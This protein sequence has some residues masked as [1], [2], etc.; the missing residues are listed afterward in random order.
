M[1][2]S[3]LV[4]VWPLSPL[5]EG[6]L[7]HALYDEQGTDVYVSQ[8]IIGLDGPLDAVA[9]RAS[10]QALLD[11]H[12]SLRAGFQRRSSGAP[13][14]LIMRR[15]VLPWREEDLSGLAED[16]AWAESERIGLEERA[17]RFDLSVPPL[18]KVLLVKVGPDRYRMMV[19]LH[20][21]LVDG[22]SLPLL[23]RE[24]WTAYEAGGSTRDLPPVTPYRE[25]LAW[26]ARQDKDAALEV[27]RKAL[28][29]TRE[30]TLVVPVVPTE[31]NAAAAPSDTVSGHASAELDA[32]LR[33]L[34]RVHGLTLNTVVQAAWA[35]M[36]GKLTGRRDVVFGA[37][38]AG[39]PA[40]LPG[41][42][43][44]LGL[45][46]N[47][48][49][50][51]VRFDPAQTVA[52]MLTELQAQQSAVM[53]HQ[54][55]GLSDI[56]RAAGPGATFDTLIAFENFPSGSKD[57]DQK[58]PGDGSATPSGPGGLKFTE[59]GVRESINYPLGLVA[60]PIGGL[61]VRMS[62]RT[63]V[64]D[65]PTARALVDRLLRLLE[66]MAADPGMRL[67]QIEV[68]DE[69]EHSLVVN[70][71]NDTAR[72]VPSGTLAELFAAQVERSPESVAVVGAEGEWSYA[73]LDRAA[74]RVA[75]ELAA[76]GVG[77]GDLVGVV[78]G[79]SADLVAVLLGVVKAGAG[80]VPVDPAYPVERI[81]F[82]LGDAAPALVVCTAATEPVVPSAQ[83]RLVFDAPDVAAAVAARS[84][85]AV[86]VGGRVEDA[87]YVIYTSGS[88][89]TP[90]GV[91]VT[92]SGIGNLAAGQIDRFGVGADSRVLQLASLSFDAAVSEICM[93]LLSGAALVVAGA[94]KLPPHGSLADVA[95]A[96][97][98]THV[99]VPPSVLAT[100][101]DL[102]ESVTT[103]VV[104]GEA[105][106]QSLVE[107]WAGGRRMVNGYG[108]TEV[109]VCATMS[110]PLSPVGDGPVPIGRPIAN[111]RL[112]LLDDCLKPVPVGT[113]AELYV[114]GPGLARGYLGRP[115]LTAE[116][117]V[118]S[119]FGGRMYRTGDLAR[120]SADGQL[121]FAGRA[122]DQVKV[123][124][125]RVE[126]GEIEAVLAT[127]E[128]VGQVAVIVRE[129]RPGDKRLVA[130]V[131]PAPAA[132]VDAGVG[133]VLR[134]LVAGRLPEY[135][136][137]S[138]VVVLEELPVTVNGKLDRSAL[139]APDFA[140]VTDGRGPAT[141][142]E[143]VVCGLFGEVLGLEW[144][145]AEASFFDLGGDS[146]LAM[147]LIARIQAVLDSSLNIGDLFAAPTA[148]GLSARIDGMK[149]AGE[150]N[151]RAAL[152]PLPRPEV[153][154]LSFAQQRM[155]FL[156]RLE[157][158]GE[159]AGYNLPLT[160]R[161]SGELDVAALEAALGDVA[162]RHESL[163]TVFPESDGAPR[164]QALEGA[165]GRPPLVIVETTEAELEEVLARH[166]GDRFDL[167]TDL[168]WR[169]RLLVTGPSE[170][171][172][173]IVAHHIAVDGWS[174]GVLARD[175][176]AAYSARCQGHA[177]GWEP[178]PVQYA[179]YA[180]W[181]RQVLGE[182]DDPE[183]LISAQLAHWRDALADVPQELV[184][185]TDRPRPAV[186]SF[187]GE[188]VPVE[189]GPRIHSRLV[190]IAQ[191]GKST[192]FMVVQAALA[193]LLSRLGAGNDIPVGTAVAGRGDSALDGLAGFF[194]NTL[195]LRTDLSGDPSF[196][197]LLA[198]VRK[199]DL[200][201]YTHQDLPFERLVEDLNPVRSLGRNPLFQVSLSMQST[202]QGQGRLWDLP[203]LR[204]RPLTAGS[205]GGGAAARVDLMV[206][207]AE[208]R[209]D[210]GSPAGIAG[211]LLYAADLFDESTARY[212]SE[213]LG[214]VLEQIAADP[215][216]SLSGIEVMEEAER[217][218]L[219]REWNA[220]DRPAAAATLPEL[221]EA[222]V[223]R[224]PDAPAV[225]SRDERW[226][227]AD[228][229]RKANR[230]A[231][232][233]IA[234]GVGRGDLVGVAMDRSADAVAVL[235]GV[236]KAGAGFVPV[237]PAY[238]AERIAFTLAD[239]AVTLV[240][241]TA[242][243]EPV[244][245]TDR[246]RLVL[247]AP[248]VI[249][250]IA[251]RP[252]DAVAVESRVEDPA[253]VIYTSGSTGTPKGVVVTHS[254]FGNLVATQAERVGI[255]AGARVLQ[256]A[257]LSFDAA[258]WEL[259]MA[260]LSG[261]ALVMAGEDRL[262]P[263]A[264]LA[265]AVAEFGVTHMS[266]S[267]SMLAAVEELPESVATIVVAAEVCPPSLVER[268]SDRRLINGYGPTEMTVAVTLSAPLSSVAEGQPV[269]IGRPITNTRAYVLDE[270]LKPVPVGVTGEL[271]AVGPGMA[272]GYLG[273]PGLSAERFVACPFT[274]PGVRMYRTGD[275][276]KWNADGQLVFAGRADDQVKVRGFRVEPGEIEAVLGTHQSVGQ[277]AVIVRE[278][279]PG[280]R[281]LVAYVVP[282]VPVGEVGEVGDAGHAGEGFG[283]ALREFVA[284][285][286]PEHMV[287]ASVVVLESLPI[288]LNGKLNRAALPA[289]DLEDLGGRA[290][291]SSLEE[292]LC[293]L[294]GE[295]LG[296]ESVGADVSFFELG[297]D[298]LLAMK[299]I[300]RIQAA[301]DTEVS[302]RALF[303][304][305]TV[306]AVAR[307]ISV[308]TGTG[309][310]AD[311]LG[312]VL[313]LRAEGEQ[314]PLFCIHP[315]SGL[316]W[317]YTDLVGHLP[318]DRPVYGLQ[319]R[320]Y[321]ADE[322]L[323]RTLEEM[324]ADYFKQIRAVQPSGPYHLLG[325]S[326]G[327][328][329]AHAVATHIQ[330]QG[331]EVALLAV[332]DGYPLHADTPEGGPNAE[333]RTKVRLLSEIRKVNDNNLQLLKNFTPG[334]FRGDLLLFVAAE[335]RPDHSPAVEA[336]DS[337]APYIDGAI[338]SIQI[339]SDHDGMLTAKPVTEIGR[340]VS[341]RLREQ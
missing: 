311:E 271:Y 296:L 339:R 247:D 125:F 194:V 226:S 160:L 324:A 107:R 272:R 261:A 153:V 140:G 65:D 56:Q 243:T 167:S 27:W 36:V 53:D 117:F 259:C 255:D 340:L 336:P 85:E 215:R 17:R 59:S 5:Q 114:Q 280:N 217:S 68:L 89:G 309:A 97:G 69:A 196:T 310:G 95:A 1:S 337:W 162:D 25:Y 232:E 218:R 179:D 151:T 249:A 60:M 143:E 173:L 41:M 190:E 313:P 16:K 115:G 156:N 213:R 223:L 274:A 168:P 330:E 169:I 241:C 121:V 109:T 199:T 289:P 290:P 331:E 191:R 50:V 300:A 276:A 48:V 251:A 316:S 238:P 139:P 134:A 55:V 31:R 159:G 101:D 20:H 253:Y 75:R 270:F 2:D 294:F 267:P 182:L 71:W 235:L 233:L 192:M 212:L 132:D 43:T 298:S 197:E 260:L 96:F 254:G 304:G 203:G 282:V 278:D 207:L 6:M 80:F 120:W 202:P 183:S 332:L 14:Q 166:A 98:V 287:P 42:E 131:V 157:G 9:L 181:Q 220:T 3:A 230:I 178:L 123:R 106:P 286:L 105:C 165:A 231:R 33:E 257:S 201:A 77:R 13:V 252:A 113:T 137:P 301:L 322:L 152:V 129:D 23:M 99:T 45:F 176:G 111:T 240:V 108:P 102:P 51:R 312:L 208:H 171:V 325:W 79:R 299:L 219:V 225:L 57:K 135:M 246:A 211:V 147:K 82:M 104:A 87:A 49:P 84:P 64:F 319:A 7:F 52:G 273:R 88:T 63:D 74:N 315:S 155:W 12:E 186:S 306:E 180:L 177:P 209:D 70:E 314:R 72:A 293:G 141:P 239:A 305:P 163:R 244:V 126:P 284:D 164:Q 275:L 119:P 138:A 295:V 189:V 34:T 214:R 320:G 205:S 264:P 145:A 268:W 277:V 61:K 195:V 237:D 263:H 78:M 216:I 40:D 4:G 35:M 47:T 321:G 222:Q 224:T 184:L 8:M 187:R 66:Q 200:A 67:G 28:E 127:H 328:T 30:P 302:I 39:R 112:Y 11:R 329:T 44:M 175:L 24:L 256:L 118:A 283:Q 307:S 15:A 91:V 242:A 37:T 266:L 150:G 297:G 73:E 90:K 133:Q 308:G 76:R 94:E 229:D 269:P 234:R 318:P 54:Y 22:W 193:V 170:Y 18:L 206:D 291:S 136:V 327:G 32:A 142:T 288:T 262:P 333:K 19:T 158:A 122:D 292:A 93:A 148:T 38:V 236:T 265:E 149:D 334:L 338:D 161:M 228:L 103:I 46:I 248:D 100:V 29:G 323:P 258:V 110:E 210:E 10:W 185:P 250:A 86:P 172:L 124:G 116:R 154:P 279:R 130:Y 144:V 128:T 92:H 81:A 303:T 285:R 326:F 317:C 21:I 341:E 58:P 198:R 335:G 221:F 146:L 227:Y 188:T 174:L 62:Y 26:L 83:V 204:V 245:P 281:R